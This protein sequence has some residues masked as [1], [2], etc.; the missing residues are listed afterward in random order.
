MA[1]GIGLRE[2]VAVGVVNVT[3]AG[4][5]RSGHR[6]QMAQCVVGVGRGDAGS[7]RTWRYERRSGNHRIFLSS[8]NLLTTNTYVARSIS[9]ITESRP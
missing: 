6:L 9:M 5:E 4:V 2:L 1:I 8:Y 3:H 7:R